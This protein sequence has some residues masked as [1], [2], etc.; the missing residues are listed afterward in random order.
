MPRHQCC[1][2]Q[3][4]SAVLLVMCFIG[5]GETQQQAEQTATNEAVQTQSV[6]EPSAPEQ[7]DATEAPQ[8][9]DDM[10]V[11]V[12]V[13]TDHNAQHKKGPSD[14]NSFITWSEANT[15]ESVA[16]LR[17]LRE[18]GVVFFCEQEARKA[19][20]GQSNSIFAYYP[21][22]PEKGG[23][24]ALMIGSVVEMSAEDFT[25]MLVLQTQLDPDNV[26]RKS[27]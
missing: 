19:T 24:V 2:N 22:V 1:P 3:I 6:A 11:M 12:T 26:A 14:W 17:R 23:I 8:N 16:A 7:Q 27:N 18:A 21:S 5:C 25:K 9:K 20:A 13:L 15:P 4:L 10:K